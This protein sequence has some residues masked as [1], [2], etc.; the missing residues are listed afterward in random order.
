MM[1]LKEFPKFPEFIRCRRGPCGHL[2]LHFFKSVYVCVCVCLR[3]YVYVRVYI[4]KT[5]IEYSM[6][7]EKGVGILWL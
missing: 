3:T 5:Y 4:G 6:A 7:E 2:L 1:R